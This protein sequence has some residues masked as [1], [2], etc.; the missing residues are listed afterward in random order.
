MNPKPTLAAM[1][2]HLVDHH[3]LCGVLE[4][5]RDICGEKADHVQANW[6]DGRTAQRW[7]SA[8]VQIGNVRDRI[9]SKGGI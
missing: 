9:H 1:L 8:S 5:L 3:S 2:E 6:Q 7:R 4:A